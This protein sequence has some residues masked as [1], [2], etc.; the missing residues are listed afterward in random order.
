MLSADEVAKVVS[1]VTGRIIEQLQQ[2]VRSWLKPWHAEHAAG[3]ITRPLRHN[4]KP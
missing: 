3:R 2:G 1:E 4:L